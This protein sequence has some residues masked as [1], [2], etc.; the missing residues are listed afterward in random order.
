MNILLTNSGRRTYF[1]EYLI[2]LKK[3]I[4]N[5]QIHIS[6]SNHYCPT[7]SYT[8]V[9]KHITPRVQNNSKKYIEN[10][11]K[12]VRNNK[13]GLLIPLTDL[14]II[15]LSQNINRFKILKC[16]PLVSSKEI[17][18]IFSNK[19]E[20]N[21]FCFENKIKTPKILSKKTLNR[22][23]KTNLVV[24]KKIS[25]SSSEGLK[26]LKKNSKIDFDKKYFF[27]EYIKGSELHFDILNDFQG[28]FLDACIKKKISMRAGETDAAM[29]VDKKKYINLAKYISSKTK[30]IGNLDCDAIEDKKK[31]IYFFDFNL[32]FGGGYA[33]THLAGYNYLKSLILLMKGKRIKLNPKKQKMILSKGISVH[34]INEN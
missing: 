7:F 25:G 20:T 23:I 2:N 26:I 11:I 15:L 24:A 14:D 29:I 6:D 27:Q 31:N 21:K 19:I 18:K 5:L 8:N 1:L 4:N 32:R 30:H 22:Y 10:I 33:F 16:I 28:N 9:K 12:I 34:K 3:K 13:I 17:S